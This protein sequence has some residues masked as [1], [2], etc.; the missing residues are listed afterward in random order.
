MYTCT[1]VCVCVCAR[2]DVFFTSVRDLCL[3][4]LYVSDESAFQCQLVKRSK[5]F[6]PPPRCEEALLD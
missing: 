1:C 2:R 6:Y 4:A 3:R 5:L